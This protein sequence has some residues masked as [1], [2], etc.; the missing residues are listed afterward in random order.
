MQS[1]L[2]ASRFGQS[3]IVLGTVVGALSAASQVRAVVLA[4][5]GFDYTPGQLLVTA[6]VGLN[7][8][9]GF[10]DAWD[11]TQGVSDSTTIEAGSLGYTDALGN[12][13]V[14]TGGK[15][16]N[17]GL[18]GTSNTPG[19]T[20]SFRR[21]GT[22]ASATTPTSTWISFLGV[23]T[24][25]LNDEQPGPP[26]SIENGTYGR[27]ANLSFFDMA[28]TITEKLNLGEN[29]AFQFPLVHGADLLRIQRLEDLTPIPLDEQFALFRSTYGKSGVLAQ[30]AVDL[31]QINAPRVDGNITAQ[32]APN[33]V[34]PED[35]TITTAREW[36]ENPVDG[37]FRSRYTQTP[38]AGQTSLM[39]VRIDHF[40]GE[41]PR[42]KVLVW[43]NP[44]LN[45]TPADGEADTVIDLAAVEQRAT[46]L[47]LTPFNA[48]DG[49]MFSF[50]RIRLFAGNLSGAR[51]AAEWLVDEL[52]VGEL[53]GDVTPHTSAAAVAGVPEPC[54]LALACLAFAI[55]AG[56]RP[57]VV[58][59]PR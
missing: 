13:L 25:A 27:G 47:A 26:P 58:Q 5:E 51:Q 39:V 34:D 43:M 15:L 20:F 49:N 23:R 33:Y 22:G 36:Q 4:Y 19:R 14:T 44:N 54:G 2:W 40:G 1:G 45:A 6:G 31:W 50:D 16:N 10:A 57:R 46:E 18:S 28:A 56:R 11:E 32:A 55:A 35:G 48:T 17:T 59:V 21:D 12:A 3:I 9:T 42:D 8:G 7:G 30:S 24:G 53:F 37:R 29:T 52:R 38:F 41:N